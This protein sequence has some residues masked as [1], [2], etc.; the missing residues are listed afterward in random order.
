[1]NFSVPRRDLAGLLVELD[2]VRHQFGPVRSG[3][4]V[5]FDDAGIGRN[6]HLLQARVGGRRVAFDQDRHLKARGGIFDSRHQFDVGFGRFDGRQKTYRRPSRASTS[7][8]VRTIGP[9]AW[10]ASLDLSGVRFD[11]CFLMPA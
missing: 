3:L 6:A 7:R 10:A 5:D 11:A 2:C 4:R 8:A 1:M 9:R